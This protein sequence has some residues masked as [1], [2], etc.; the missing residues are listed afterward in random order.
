[1]QLFLV[2]LIHRVPSLDL[3]PCF[4]VN[5]NDWCSDKSQL[6]HTNTSYIECW[7][8]LM[9]QKEISCTT[10]AILFMQSCWEKYYSKNKKILLLIKFYGHWRNIGC[11]QKK[12]HMIDFYL[13]YIIIAHN[14]AL[15]IYFCALIVSKFWFV[16]L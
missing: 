11:L 6:F 9:H 1:M 7:K 3:S 8:Y 5:L 4:S 14:A 10:L 12:S 15:Y 2:K 13:V 16:I